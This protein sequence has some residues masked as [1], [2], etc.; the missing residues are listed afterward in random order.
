LCYST[1][2]PV[3]N[4]GFGRS[5]VGYRDETMAP[6]VAFFFYLAAVLCFALGAVGRGR[7]L[8]AVIRLQPALTLVP[9]ALTFFPTIFNTAL[10]RL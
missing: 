3:K 2:H 9:M 4:A 1:Q 5:A 7:H 8:G 6:E 10:T